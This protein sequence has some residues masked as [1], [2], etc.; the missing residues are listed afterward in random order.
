MG[1]PGA[2][3]GG[4]DAA[5][6]QIAAPATAAMTNG[7]SSVSTCSISRVVFVAKRLIGA[8]G[9]VI[10]LMCGPR[11]DGRFNR[12]VGAQQQNLLLIAFA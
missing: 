12:E 2:V 5:A 1:C 11:G 4:R 7:I 10:R 3:A 6:V 8:V 9:F